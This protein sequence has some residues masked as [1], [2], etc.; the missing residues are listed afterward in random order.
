MSN[1]YVLLH[2]PTMG[3]LSDYP[4]LEGKSG[5]EALNNY[6]PAHYIGT[7]KRIRYGETPEYCLQ[8][9]TIRDGH[10][11]SNGHKVWYKYHQP[12]I[13]KEIK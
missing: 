11:F 10:Y 6:L 4:L 7:V 8:K 1:K 12:V 2:T 5:I 3:L 9:I 13:T